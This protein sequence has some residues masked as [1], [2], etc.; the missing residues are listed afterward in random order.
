MKKTIYISLIIGSVLFTACS[1]SSDKTDKNNKQ[2]IKKQATIAKKSNEIILKDVEGNK[3]IVTKTKKGYTFS[4]AKNK[5]VMISF[6]ATWCPPCIAEIPHLNNL[7]EKYKND[8]S[9]IGISLEENKSNSDMKKFINY[10]AINYTISNSPGNQQL[11]KAVGG[12][13]NIPFMIMYNKNGDYV[14]NYLGAVP[15]EMIDS[16]IESALKK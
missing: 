10:N 13:N 1:S 5:I 3:I 2:D 7:Q 8:I 16:D 4:N 6:F 12:V 14:T 9:I 15:Q 11:A